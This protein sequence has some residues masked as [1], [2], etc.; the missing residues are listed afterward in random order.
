MNGL[1]SA[2]LSL[3]HSLFGPG[4]CPGEWVW[5][6]SAAG[7]LVALLPPIGAVAVSIIRKGTGNRYDAT[8]LGVFGGIGLVSALVLPWLLSNGVSGVY[9][10]AF[11]GDKTGLSRAELASLGRDGGCW[12]GNQTKYLGGG[13]TV[14]DVLF[15]KNGSD[16]PF[17]VYLLAFAVLGAGSLFF[18]ML[19]GRTA[20]RRGPKWPSRFFWIPFAAML[21]F[22]VGMEANTA[23]H[24]LLGF[25]P[26]SVLGLIPVAMVGPPPWSV[27]NRSDRP[28]T[29]PRREP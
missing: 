11:G 9:R 20:F 10:A 19:Q 3:A 18:V 22:S 8:T 5:A 16:L 25:L 17:F 1:A 29:P 26:F 24:F 28:D 27:I 14:Y 4:F 6:T 21:V 7:A 15:S 12:V 23:L 2:L 13:Q